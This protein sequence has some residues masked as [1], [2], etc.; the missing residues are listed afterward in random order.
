MTEAEF[1]VLKAR[2]EDRYRRDLE[3]LERIRAIS[4][5]V[6]S[7]QSTPSP[8]G[9]TALTAS[10]IPTSS[11]VRITHPD[12]DRTGQNG[13]GRGEGRMDVLSLVEQAT[14]GVEGEFTS[15]N[16]AEEIVFHHPHLESTLKRSSVTSALNRLVDSDRLLLVSKGK[17]KRPSRYRCKEDFFR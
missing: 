4:Q 15:S 3:A 9:P 1:S 5:E 8:S 2:I 17:G 13:E 11:V 16:V 14:M 12:A 7:P 10:I 6:S